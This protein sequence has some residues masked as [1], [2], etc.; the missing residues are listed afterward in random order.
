MFCTIVKIPIWRISDTKSLRT[1]AS[2]NSLKCKIT[3]K[4]SGF[5]SESE[6]VA[7]NLRGDAGSE[8]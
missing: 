1:Y 6:C 3:A 2:F 4:E 5:I 8:C 7:W